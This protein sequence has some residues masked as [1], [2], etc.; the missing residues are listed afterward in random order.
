MGD[1]DSVEPSLQLLGTRFLNFLLRKLSRDFKLRR[2][3][4]LHE[5]KWLYFHIARG[6]SHMVGHA[7]SPICIA[8]TDV[9]LT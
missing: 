9:T 5:F 6:Y 1:Y 7:G 8:H 4:I 2:T 3:S